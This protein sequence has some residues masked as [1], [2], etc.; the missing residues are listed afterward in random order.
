MTAKTHARPRSTYRWWR[1][2]IAKE[3][4]SLKKLKQR[5]VSAVMHELKPAPQWCT[6]GR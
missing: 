5:T 4:R 3:L 6:A 1:R 2:E